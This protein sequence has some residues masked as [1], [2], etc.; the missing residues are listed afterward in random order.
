METKTK[1][2]AILPVR[3]EPSGGLLAFVVPRVLRIADAA[4]Y[5]SATTCQTS[6]QARSLISQ[7]RHRIDALDHHGAQTSTK[8]GSFRCFASVRALG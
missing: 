6:A 8:I 3:Q 1:Y 2:I 4:K 5:L 7:C